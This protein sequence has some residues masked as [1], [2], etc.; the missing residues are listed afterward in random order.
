[1]RLRLRLTLLNGLVVLLAVFVFAVV[2]Y[3]LQ[4]QALLSN[5]DASL[6]DQARWYSDN[7]SLWYDR[8]RRSPRA[9]VFPNPQRF[10]APD[11]FIQITM[12]D[13]DTVARSRNLDGE[14][15]PSDQQMLG[16]TL[17]GEAWFTNIE[18]DGQPLRMY[19]SPLRTNML[20]EEGGPIVGMIQVARPLWPTYNSLHTLQTSFVSVGALGVLAALVLGWML[21]RAALRPI[22]RLAA[23]A[24]AIG[25]TRDFSQR[26]PIKSRGRRDEVGLLAEEFNR[27]LARLQE[28][29]EQVE[30]ALAAQRRFVADASHELRTPLTSLRGNVDLLR[31]TIALN[32]SS[33]SNQEQEQLLADMAAETERLARLVNDLL[34]L[35][36]ADAGQHLS[37]VPTEV[38]P[39]VHDAFRAARFLREG[40]E[41]RLGEVAAAAWVNGDADRLKQLLLILLDNGLKY[42]PEGGRVTIEARPLSRQG[43]PGIAIR[44]TDTGPG[45]RPEEHA[46]IFER[47]YRA[48]RVRRTGGSGLGLAIARWIVDEHHGTIEVDS[49]PGHGSTFTVWLP[50]ATPQQVT[51][52]DSALAGV[53]AASARLQNQPRT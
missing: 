35:A 45:I 31:R 3:A 17:Q 4:Q 6:R 52:N 10:A 22:D 47:F 30:T 25:A 36:R 13:G 14:R 44:V 18:M 42:T 40:V 11:I 20:E 28:A 7:A 5:L 12:R 2:A 9:V 48:D 32:S 27:M 23:A 53:G 16:R 1:M 49:Q 29:Y 8:A 33:F 24:H 41:L 26:V 38:A 43:A 51:E 21:A 34:L 39:L 15:L 37:L 19:I 46:R 50:A